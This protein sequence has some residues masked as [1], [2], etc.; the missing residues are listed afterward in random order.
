MLGRN[1]WR[2]LARLS[3]SPPTVTTTQTP[4]NPALPPPSSKWRTCG[5]T[6]LLHTWLPAAS[7]ADTTGGGPKNVGYPEYG[8]SGVSL[9]L[10]RSPTP[11]LGGAKRR[12]FESH[13]SDLAGRNGP[14]Q[15]SACGQR[16]R[17]LLVP[18][19]VIDGAVVTPAFP[20]QQPQGL[21]GSVHSGSQS[22][23]KM[24]SI[25]GITS[26]GSRVGTS[27][28]APVVGS[29]EMAASRLWPPS[30]RAARSAE[31]FRVQVS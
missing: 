3:R 18:P 20:C 4:S 12:Q 29:V 6:Q 11:H 15:G 21:L 8:P 14:A 28:R 19:N 10:I 9:A 31:P 23:D 7:S 24:A 25:M 13:P 27:S 2:T 26:C 30:A 1:A 16:A 5:W 22:H 17:P